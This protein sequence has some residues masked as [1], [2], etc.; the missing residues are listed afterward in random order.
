[1]SQ[2][3]LNKASS[4]RS[5]LAP[6]CRACRQWLVG[7]A[8]PTDIHECLFVGLTLLFALTS[9]LIFLA[10]NAIPILVILKLYKIRLNGIFY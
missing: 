7:A 8:N 9:A 4:S 5:G 2:P 1:M 6:F 10:L 3:L